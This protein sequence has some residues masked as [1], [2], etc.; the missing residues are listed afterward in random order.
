MDNID[1]CI[2]SC[3]HSTSS[4]MMT[5]E[6]LNFLLQNLHHQCK[7]RAE[8][9]FPLDT[10]YEILHNVSVNMKDFHGLIVNGY[11]EHE[12]VQYVLP[13]FQLLAERVG[14]FLWHDRLDRDS[15]LFK[16]A[17][18]LMKIIPIELE[19]M[20]ICYTNLKSSP[21]A[22][23]GCFIKQ[24]LETSPDNLGEYLIHL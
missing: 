3:H 23:V 13:Q 2:S 19:V 11:I 18:L 9:I 14:I 20:H 17:H 21:S 24:F 8:Q 4:A 12:I 15:R 1:D 16:L 10:Q 5:E 7:Y 6:Q 22:E